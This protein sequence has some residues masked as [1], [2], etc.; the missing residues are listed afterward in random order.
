MSHASP[1][2]SLL[3]RRRCRFLDGLAVGCAVRGEVS[4]HEPF[5]QA[6]LL[7]CDVCHFSGMIFSLIQAFCSGALL[8][9]CSGKSVQPVR[10]TKAFWTGTDCLTSSALCHTWRAWTSQ[11]GR[12]PTCLTRLVP[13]TMCVLT[14][15]AIRSQVSCQA[16]SGLHRG[17]AE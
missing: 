7:G 16:P 4:R 8:T 11:F 13:A 1:V 2:F 6:G 14:S 9:V 10:R 15:Q 5:G 12:Q 3:R 17:C